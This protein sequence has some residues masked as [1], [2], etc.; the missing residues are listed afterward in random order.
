VCFESVETT[1]CTCLECLKIC[2]T[3]LKSLNCS[4]SSSFII[5]Y[6]LSKILN[7]F[8]S[9]SFVIAYSLSK[10]CN[11]FCILCNSWIILRSI[12]WVSSNPISNLLKSIVWLRCTIYNKSYFLSSNC[13]N[14]FS[15]IRNNFSVN[16]NWTS[17][18]F[19]N[20]SFFSSNCITI[21]FLS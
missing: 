10:S 17:I 5:T 20:T 1:C 6:N 9:S 11:I 15:F 13:T 2:S 19:I 4:I 21:C 16:F 8:I 7:C 18:K 12:S 3:S 14:R